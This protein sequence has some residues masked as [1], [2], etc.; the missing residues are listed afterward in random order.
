ML[1]SYKIASLDELE[2]KAK[3]LLDP[4]TYDY[5]AGGA[6]SEWGITNSRK[7]FH[8][9]QIVP[10]VL[11]NIN[12]IDTSIEIFDDRITSPV[13]IAP[14]AFHKLVCDDG[15]LA[16]A[17]AAEKSGTIMTLSTMSSFSIEEVANIS[18]APKWFQLYVF[19]N[20]DITKDLVT[21]AEKCGYHAIVVT[22]DVPGVM[23]DRRRDI[24]NQFSLPSKVEAANFREVD[25]SFLSTK[26]EGSKIKDHTDQQFDSI[27]WDTIKWLRSITKLPIILK[28]ILNQEDAIEALQHN[29]SGIIVS[30]HGGRQI[31][32]VIAPIDA[33][34]NISRVIGNRIPLFID[35]GFNSGED[36]FKAIALGARAVMIARPVLWALTIGNENAVIALLQKLQEELI[37]IMRL[38]SC[39]SLSAIRK[40]G[41]SLLT[42]PSIFQQKMLELEYRLSHPEEASKNTTTS[43]NKLS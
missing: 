37:L 43:T 6:G 2:K 41:L 5:I 29:I 17:K 11:Q 1:T 24:E 39:P 26:T 40:H 34:Y 15:E 18:S 9:Y 3:E 10:R 19:K 33:L 20:R 22:V 7:A 14:C 21:R 16:T 28:G 31:D 12:T 23:G 35:G 38:A 27:T 4:S 36:I 25:L 32:S 42:G 8:G 13:M 30:N